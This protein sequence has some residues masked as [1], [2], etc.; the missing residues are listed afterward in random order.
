MWSRDSKS[1]GSAGW[2]SGTRL[3]HSGHSPQRWDRHGVCGTL[4]TAH[5]QPE[6]RREGGQAGAPSSWPGVRGARPP[7]AGVA[8]FLQPVLVC[9]FRRSENAGLERNSRWSARCPGFPGQRGARPSPAWSVH[10]PTRGQVCAV[11][12][13]PAPRPRR[14]SRPRPALGDTGA[15]LPG[16]QGPLACLGS[17]RADAHELGHHWGSRAGA[18]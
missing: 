9:G 8:S 12:R 11:S 14:P 2:A 1:R 13:A 15:V 10:T 17:Q 18:G 16:S 6:A 4:G 7:G 3:R 5:E